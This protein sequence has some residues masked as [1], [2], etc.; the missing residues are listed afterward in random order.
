[1]EDLGDLGGF[2]GFDFGVGREIFEMR[3]EIGLKM[4][5]KL[6]DSSG[7]SG[8]VATDSGGFEIIIGFFN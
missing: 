4:V 7:D 3:I 8:V 5:V 2:A 1:M 6:S